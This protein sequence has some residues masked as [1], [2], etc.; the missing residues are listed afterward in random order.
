MAEQLIP[1]EIISDR[2]SLGETGHQPA[3]CPHC[4]R[5][6]LIKDDRIGTNCPLCRKAAL[7]SQSARAR[8]GQ[9]ELILPFKVGQSA[10]LP[11]YQSFVSAVWIRPDDFNPQSLLRRSVPLFWPLWL[12]D[13]DI[14][15]KWQMEAGFNYQ[16]ESTKEVFAGGQ[17][18][19]R[20]QIE[21]RIRWEPRLGKLETRVDNV[22]LPALEEHANRRQL[23]GQYPLDKAQP[24][25]SKYLGDALI[26][27]PD[28][29]PDEAWPL[30]RPQVDRTAAMVCVKAAAADHSRNFTLTAEYDNQ[31]WTQFLL[32]LYATFYTDDNGQPQIV[33]V[34][35]FNG[36]IHGPQMASR[37]RGLQIAGIIAAV[38]GVFL[39]LALIALLLTPILAFAG[40]I[41][42]MCALLGLGT[43]I[44]AIITV[45][46]PAQWNNSQSPP[47]I[48]TRK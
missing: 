44:A 15:G 11:I 35:G 33:L 13:T 39:L 4:G 31:H 48:V 18:D 41:A 20:K 36:E 47:R 17:W 28:L 38:A 27:I 25:D 29:P 43:G 6:F 3:G 42:A 19:S 1:A 46:Q 8:P 26:E 22:A 32:P 16:V 7:E 34:N 5:V 23:T 24:F 30:A 40:V 37:K 2:T 9:P 14:R 45:V 10:L 21:D 12:V